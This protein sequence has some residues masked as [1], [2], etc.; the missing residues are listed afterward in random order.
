MQH[1]LERWALNPTVVLWHPSTASLHSLSLTFCPLPQEQTNFRSDPNRGT[2]RLR[3][4]QA[5]GRHNET[6]RSLQRGVL[7]TAAGSGALAHHKQLHQRLLL[8]SCERELRPAW[9]CCRYH[10]EAAATGRCSHRQAGPGLKSGPALPHPHL[11]RATGAPWG[12]R[13]DV[14]GAAKGTGRGDKA[15][16]L[17]RLFVTTH[18]W[19]RAPSLRL[20]EKELSPL[21]AAAGQDP[22]TPSPG[23]GSQHQPFRSSYLDSVVGS[24]SVFISV[25]SAK[26][27]CCCLHH[28]PWEVATLGKTSRWR[29]VILCQAVQGFAYLQHKIK[30]PIAR[31]PSVL[32]WSLEEQQVSCF[33]GSQ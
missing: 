14:A 31:T 7:T 20:D 19:E 17:V 18:C 15:R 2:A 8:G 24:F 27:A 33:L 6:C 26:R 3:A 29:G 1:L 13:A 5:A 9:H 30:L 11:R 22:S 25:I 10:G 28:R 4:W 21:H 16:G 32:L 23:Q 12:R